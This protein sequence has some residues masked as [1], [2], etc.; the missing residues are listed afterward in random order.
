[1]D[2]DA[3]EWGIGPDRL[4]FPNQMYVKEGVLLNKF[5]GIWPIKLFLPREIFLRLCICMIISGGI[6]PDNWFEARFS[7][8]SLVR[9]P[10][11][12]GMSLDRLF[13]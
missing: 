8:S 12:A 2:R 3:M 7:N 10:R 5:G 9:F 1:M 13:P 6:W 4:L 11:A